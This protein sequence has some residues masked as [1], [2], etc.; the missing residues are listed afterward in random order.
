VIAALASAQ[1]PLLR[2]VNPDGRPTAQLVRI[3]TTSAH[4]ATVRWGRIPLE[5][6]SS[7]CRLKCLRIADHVISRRIVMPAPSSAM[8]MP[9][10]T[11]TTAAVPGARSVTSLKV[12][13]ASLRVTT[14]F[15]RPVGK[16]A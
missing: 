9:Q 5:L 11:S 7:R 12:R 16:Y 6:G 13:S 1:V 14:A 4:S 15:T 2:A 3:V 8:P 10:T